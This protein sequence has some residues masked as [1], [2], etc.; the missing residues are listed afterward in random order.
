MEQDQG[1]LSSI[2]KALDLLELLARSE[3]SVS[4]ADL[5]AELGM[6]KSSVH[7]LLQILLRRGYISKDE[8]SHAYALGL[9]IFALH[10]LPAQHRRLVS[11]TRSH[12]RR[13]AGRLGLS[14]NLAVLD[15]ERLGYWVHSETPTSSA[16]KVTTGDRAPLHCAG[17][18][19]MLLAGLDR[20]RRRAVLD[21]LV[22]QAKTPKTITDR[23]E[24]EAELDRIADRGHA[25]DDEENTLGIRCVAAPI[26]SAEG[27][28]VAAI[29]LTALAPVMSPDR[30][31]DYAA[32]I[33][34]AA[35]ELSV[36]LGWRPDPDLRD[37]GLASVQRTGASS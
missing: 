9:R 6:P 35:R 16:A 22:L 33:M 29:S 37:G 19:K 1:N 11:L 31:E 30:I 8:A 17:L 34:A 14:V 27:L 36:Q 13:L 7:R 10:N 2:D 23:G 28:V 25:I 5:A 4:L 26:R 12:L 21:R 3:E 20:E 18:G 24:L 15:P 32:E